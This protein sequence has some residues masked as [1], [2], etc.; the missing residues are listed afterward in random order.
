MK[1]I[2]YE[3]T[4]FEKEESEWAQKK[5]R[6][7]GSLKAPTIRTFRADVEDL[8]QEK[9]TT[10]TQMVMAEATRREQRGQSR[11]L[12]EED[13]SHLGRVIFLLV[14]V[15]TFGVGVGAYVLLGSRVS[16]PFLP[17][18]PAPVEKPVTSD[19][20]PIIISD[21]PRE[22]ILADLSIAFGKTSLLEGG[23][24]SV[25]F[26]V[27]DGSGGTQP[28]TTNEVLAAIS[29]S[30]PPDD[31]LR[32][33]DDPPHY[34]IYSQN[35]LTGYLQLPSRSYPNT[36]A[37]MLEWEP[38]MAR[39]LIP[40]LDPWYGRKNIKDLLGR[41]FKDE[42]ID[43]FDARILRDPSGNTLIAYAFINKKILIITESTDTLLAIKKKLA[44]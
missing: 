36:F 12:R 27:K 31:L 39:D 19:E 33:F 40:V 14:L 26:T 8:I 35:R 44:Q 22:Q 10:K 3:G 28:A 23:T 37:G 18:K 15:L 2:S 21:S 43:T 16:L 7:K 9:G 24:R 41:T 38:T 11:V 32:S 13:G 20:L 6:S 5:E 17:A 1:E 34:G 4:S 30:S 25:V 29:F 42:H